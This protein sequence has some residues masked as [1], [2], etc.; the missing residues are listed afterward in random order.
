V[1]LKTSNDRFVVTRAQVEK[2]IERN[3]PL[4][5]KMAG[6]NEYKVPHR[7]FIALPPKAAYVVVFGPEGGASMFSHS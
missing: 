5:L 6:G 7:D 4:V 2:A 3:R 1:K